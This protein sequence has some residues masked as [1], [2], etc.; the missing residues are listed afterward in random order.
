MATCVTEEMETIV[1]PEDKANIFESAEMEAIK[2]GKIYTVIGQFNTL[3]KCLKQRGW[4]E[5]YKVHQVLKSISEDETSDIEIKKSKFIWKPRYYP[6]PLEMIMNP[7]LNRIDRARELDYTFKDGLKNCAENVHW[8]LNEDMDEINIPRTH[9]LTDKE[10]HKLFFEDFKLTKTLGFLTFLNN[11]QDFPS[12]FSKKGSI[13]VDCIELAL[14]KLN[15]F[16]EL[17]VDC[18]VDLVEPPDFFT[19]YPHKY[20]KMIMDFFQITELDRKFKLNHEIP[21]DELKQEI[22]DVIENAVKLWPNR[23]YDGKFLENILDQSL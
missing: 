19:K 22:N 11:S 18:D 4:I 16:M 17:N 23:R 14:K 7:L 9:I 13:S 10:S 5:N 2:K 8:H 3:K 20:N 1:Q 15:Q 6:Y 12:L 21:L